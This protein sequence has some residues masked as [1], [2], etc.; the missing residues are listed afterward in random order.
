MVRIHRLAYIY[1]LVNRVDNEAYIG[2]TCRT[3][4]MRLMEHKKSSLDNAN[5]RVYDHLGKIGWDKVD[6]V[7]IRRYENI[8]DIDLRKKEAYYIKLIGTL[9]SQRPM[10]SK[11]ID[12]YTK[13]EIRTILSIV[14]NKMYNNDNV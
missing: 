11:C 4:R 10:C 8:M 9:N 2:R 12:E 3:L 6:I 7:P 1:A 5:R 14:K 13:D